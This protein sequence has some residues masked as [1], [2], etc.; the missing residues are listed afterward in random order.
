MELQS[1]M[2]IAANTGAQSTNIHTGSN[3]FNSSLATS[4]LR[5]LLL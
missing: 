3:C 5:N 1:G 2:K 4:Y